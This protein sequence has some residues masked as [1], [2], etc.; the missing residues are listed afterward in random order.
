MT[1]LRL[2]VAALAAAC[3]ALPVWAEAP[4][5][6]TRAGARRL[7]ARID[8]F[9]AARWEKEGVQPAAPADDA[10]FLRRL[11]L[12]VAGRIPAVSDVRRFLADRSADKRDRLID[13]MLDSPAYARHFSNAWLELLAPEATADY[14]RR[15]LLPGL[16]AW[17]RKEF[18]ENVP[19]D[20]MVRELLTLPF[21]SDP[22]QRQFMRA[23]IFRSDAEP[24]PVGYYIAKESKPE[25]LA[26]STARLFLGVRLECAQCHDHPFG[27]WTR[28]QFWAQAAFFA[29]LRPQRNGDVANPPVEVPDRRELPI[30]N[31]ERVAQARF[32]D[33]TEPQWRFKTSARTTLANWITRRD[34]PFFARAAVNRLW[35]H[36]FGTGFV[37]PVDDFHDANPPACPELLDELARQFADHGF[38]FKFLIRAIAHSKAYQVQSVRT[39]SSPHLYECMAVKGLTP[40]QIY[41]SFVQATG[42]RDPDGSDPRR[43]FSYDGSPRCLFLSKFTY[44]EN[45]T[46][47]Q[48][49]IPQALA[50][51]NSRLAAEVTDPDKGELLAAVANAPFLDTRGRVEALFLATLSRPPRSDEAARLVAYVDKGGATGDGKKALADVF[52]AL[53]NSTEFLFNH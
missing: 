22:R 1:W 10:T 27:R 51:M 23:A 35:A 14:Q 29:G 17:L 40:L 46:E 41:D 50:L 31:T 49:S 53:L 8:A 33:G 20:R 43:R 6:A 5:P 48:T 36:F 19:Y 26:A 37:E 52:W 44:Q 47:V 7:A 30:P 39:G 42:Y 25:N 2:L 9:L 15:F 21:G 38:D 16:D 24:S 12:D 4:A 45:R 18:T 28:E 3:A 11:S 34:N 32:L 13:E